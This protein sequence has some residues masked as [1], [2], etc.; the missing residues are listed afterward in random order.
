M[1]AYGPPSNPRITHTE[2]NLSENDKPG[3]LAV[4][5]GQSVCQNKGKRFSPSWIQIEGTE[6]WLK[7]L[8]CS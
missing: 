5:V 4:D 8:A 3:T 6:N 7:K 1:C 2:A